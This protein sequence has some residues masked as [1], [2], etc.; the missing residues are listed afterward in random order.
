MKILAFNGSPRV[1][2]NTASM[3]K[4]ILEEAVKNGHETELINIYDLNLKG[5]LACRA[6]KN[7]KIEYCVVQDGLH[8]VYPRIVEADVLI[9]GSPIYIG[10]ITGPMKIL[11]D[12]FYTF[13]RQDYTVRDLPGKRFI[14][15]I[16]S[17]AGKETYPEVMEYLNSWM[18]KF[19]RMENI[20][21]LQI[22]NMINPDDAINSA[23]H[24]EDA[25]KLGQ[26]I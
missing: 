2:G 24:V 19:F 23:Q 18:S 21:S 3:I 26:S 7:G 14:N 8:D 17:G 20:G 11:V 16:T 1:N 25:K 4:V 5:C 6:C 9:F 22:G 13:G 15:V 12:R 10:H